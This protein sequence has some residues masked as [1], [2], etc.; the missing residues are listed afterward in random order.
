MSRDGADSDYLSENGYGFLV[1]GDIPSGWGFD[2][3]QEEKESIFGTFQE[4]KNWSLKNNG[5]AF[6]RN[7]NGSG[8]I[9]KERRM[10]LE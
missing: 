1:E 6:T 9:S 3:P 4:A 7:P 10:Y 5:G 8:Y 2:E